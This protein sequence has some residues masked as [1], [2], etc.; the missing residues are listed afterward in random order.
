MMKYTPLQTVN[1]CHREL[2][3]T[4]RLMGA[5]EVQLDENSDARMDLGEVEKVLR[6]AVVELGRIIRAMEAKAP[7]QRIIRPGADLALKAQLAKA[8][9]AVASALEEREDGPS[10]K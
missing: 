9:Q 1:K 6:H 5:A 7:N 2:W 3:W 10:H 4:I 8:R